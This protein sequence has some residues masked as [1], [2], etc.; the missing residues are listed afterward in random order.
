MAPIVPISLLKWAEVRGSLGE[1]RVGSAPVLGLLCAW[2]AVRQSAAG[3]A[4][5]RLLL[6]GASLL[7]RR[8][9]SGPGVFWWGRRLGNSGLLRA[10]WASAPLPTGWLIDVLRFCAGSLLGRSVSVTMAGEY[11]KSLGGQS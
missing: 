10:L 4:W 11:H 6:T 9:L 7:S 3:H 2:S 5:Q 1:L 8:V